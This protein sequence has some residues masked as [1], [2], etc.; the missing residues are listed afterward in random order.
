MGRVTVGLFSPHSV[1][2]CERILWQRSFPLKAEDLIVFFMN[3][4]TFLSFLFFFYF[5][6]T[7]KNNDRHIVSVSPHRRLCDGRLS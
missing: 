6:E 7:H 4:Y 3:E 5:H 1:I 2:V